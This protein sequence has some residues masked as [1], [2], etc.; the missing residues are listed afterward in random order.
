MGLFSASTSPSQPSAP[1]PSPDGGFEAPNRNARAH[2]WQARDAFF[3]C[4][5]RNAIVDSIKDADQAQKLLFKLSDDIL[6]PG[7]L[8][9]FLRL[10]VQVMRMVMVQPLQSSVFDRLGCSMRDNSKEAKQ[11]ANNGMEKIHCS[12]LRIV[13]AC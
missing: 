1:K 9:S 5:E 10:T 4:L 8:E 6:D 3:G 13:P 11:E 2:C 12:D 7:I